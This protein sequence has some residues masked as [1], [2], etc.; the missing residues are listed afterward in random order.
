MNLRDVYEHIARVE[1]AFPVNELV[2]DGENVWLPV[3][4]LLIR[5]FF[6]HRLRTYRSVLR[7]G[8]HSDPM[9]WELQNRSILDLRNP[10]RFRHHA[11]DDA[12]LFNRH[13]QPYPEKTY[14]QPVDILIFHSF[15]DYGEYVERRIFNRVSDGIREIYP[16]GDRVVKLLRSNASAPLLPYFH[17]THFYYERNGAGVLPEPVEGEA[18]LLDR[19]R[20]IVA[21]CGDHGIPTIYLETSFLNRLRTLF[22][23]ARR[24][25][26]FLDYFQP[27]AVFLSSYSNIERTAMTLAGWRS[28]IPVVD[29]EHG[30]MG[31]YSPYGALGIV[32]PEGYRLLPRW[33]W[34]WGR[35]NLDFFKRSLP[36]GCTAH[37]PVIG[38]STWHFARQKLIAE[39]HL[40]TDVLL[41][42]PEALK[43]RLSA[44]RRTVLFCWQPDMLVH[45]TEPHLLPP[46]FLQGAARCPEDILFAVRLHP[47]SHHL[48]PAFERLLKEA[49]LANWEIEETTRVPLPELLP[50][51]DLL[52]TSYST[53]AFE[54][55]ALK[56]PV[57]LVDAFG[58]R[59]MAHYL[60]SGIFHDGT[61][62]EHLARLCRDG[63]DAPVQPVD[64]LDT[65]PETARAAFQ[66]ILDDRLKP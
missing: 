37:R 40:T 10:P 43:A 17:P 57:A 32:P 8:S 33:F 14:G 21:W 50:R 51:T 29:V 9:S 24:F 58:C 34:V 53:V 52:L 12:V 5:P 2:L 1:A 30:Y 7:E 54:A 38:G 15:T 6:E 49:G 45:E 59:M 64:Y 39:N 55:N 35:E 22:R 20:R 60:A 16:A 46:A 56:I 36:A 11:I 27:R 63:P 23:R 18:P 65:R 31:P 25:Q 47:R 3:R 13:G 41:G 62:P 28:G 4:D 44:A 48:I 42:L 66:T 19:L 26:A 61:D